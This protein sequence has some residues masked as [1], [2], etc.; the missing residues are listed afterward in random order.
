MDSLLAIK[1]LVFD[2][3]A[4]TMQELVAALKANWKGYEVLQAMAKNRAP[5]Y[6]RDDDEAD[7]S[8]PPG[9]AA[10]VR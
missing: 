6:G 2:K 9:D 3:K 4:C 10:V 5:K 8:R 7:A 1:Y